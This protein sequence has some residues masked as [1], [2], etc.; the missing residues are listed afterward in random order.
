MK[1]LAYSRNRGKAY[2]VSGIMVMLFFVS[3]L[4]GYAYSQDVGAQVPV[5]VNVDAAVRIDPPDG[6]GTGADSSVTGGAQQTF[7]IKL[8]EQS[9]VPVLHRP[10]KQDRD[11]AWVSRS[12]G[13][14][15][16]NLHPQQYQNAAVSLHSLNGKRVLSGKASAAKGTAGIS[17]ANIPAGVYLL[18]VKGTKGSSF[19]ARLTHSGG[20]LN[21]N[22]AYG[23]AGNPSLRKG[24]ADDAGYGEW[25]ITVSAEGYGTQTRTFF[26]A[27]GVN[28]AQSFTLI[29]D[30]GEGGKYSLSVTRS[31]TAGGKVFVGNTE[32]AGTTLH[33]AGTQAAVRAEAAVGYVFSEWSGSLTSKNA[34]LTLNM[35]SNVTL[36]AN[37]VHVGAH[38][39]TIVK[40][41]ADGGTV[42]VNNVDTAGVTTH[43]TGTQVTIKVTAGADYAFTKWDGASTSADTVITLTM[44]SDQ[45]LTALFK[46]VYFR[47]SRD[48]S[49]YR[50]TEIG[51]QVWMAENLN[52][53]AHLLGI[54][55]CHNRDSTNCEKYGRLYNWDA[56]TTACPAGWHLPGNEEWETLINFAGNN[57]AGTKLK[58]KTGWI[59]GTTNTDEYGFSALPGGFA[60]YRGNADYDFHSFNVNDINA[61][62]FGS[63][64][65][66]TED[67][68]GTNAWSHFIGALD[69]RIENAPEPK[70]NL[71]SVRCIKN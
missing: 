58:A 65:S 71:N 51:T 12:R 33:N 63:W 20:T 40:S 55:M 41:L 30:S 44:N 9:D 24:A 23:G 21:I 4:T 22:A 2:A 70:L 6:R 27:A 47:D 62:V 42:L 25:T 45:T 68:A 3:V 66:A 34:S 36:T 1:A 29:S 46:L 28:A 8:S 32:S 17:R 69:N 48:G 43:T 35:H 39:L 31:P 14:I 61:N 60:I 49:R 59:I 19:S 67:N 15:T 56:A 10:Q 7:N 37:F 52:F 54:S 57:T 64:W 53:S 26:P 16:I 5:V 50:M 38:K 18:S 11:G 13:N